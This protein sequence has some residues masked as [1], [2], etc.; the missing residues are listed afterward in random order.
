MEYLKASS[1]Q[2]ILFRIRSF[3]ASFIQSWRNMKWRMRG[4]DV[5]PSTTFERNIEMDRLYPTGI[6]IGKNCLISSGVSILSH[7]H[8][9]RTGEG[10]TGPL[11]M[12]TYIGERCFIATRAL[13]LG[14]VKIGNE[15]IIGAGAVVTKDVP[16]NTI[17]AGN[18][19]KII[20][21]GIKMSDM[22]TLLN[23]SPDK[24][25]FEL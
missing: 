23:W 14:G 9:K 16:D 12:D 19:A 24:G 10:I 11:L 1:K 3:V 7:D 6:H 5:H 13:I 21:T 18:P 2:K 8:C 17:V 4:Y 15:C 25:Y 20:R 22:A